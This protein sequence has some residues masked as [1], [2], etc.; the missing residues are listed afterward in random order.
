MTHYPDSSFLVSCYIPD[1]NTPHAQVCLNRIQAPLAFTALHALEVRN[2]FKLG[3]FRGLFTAKDAASAWTNL[4]DDLGSGRLVKTAVKWPVA[5][6]EAVH[7]SERHS[8]TIGTHSLDILHIASA[9][10][11]RAADLLS[12]DVRQRSLAQLVGLVVAP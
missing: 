5:F 7:L 12:F 2:A 3:V 10:A 1:V 4:E 6:R 11:I 8:V 9:K